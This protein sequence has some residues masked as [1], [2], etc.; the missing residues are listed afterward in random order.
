VPGVPA[1]PTPAKVL[2][3]SLGRP[4]ACDGTYPEAIAAVRARGAVIVASAGNSTGHA[5]NVPANCSGVIGVAAVR[6]IGTKVGFSDVGPELTIAAPGGNCVNI[7]AGQPCLFPIVTTSNSGTTTPGS[8]IYTDSFNISVGT[9]FSAPLVSATVALMVSANS[10]LTPDQVRRLLRSTARSFPGVGAPA[11]DLG[12][13]QTCRPPDG[14]DQLQCYCT[15]LT[16]GAGLLDA[17]AAVQQSTQLVAFIDEGVNSAQAGQTITFTSN[18]T[19]VPAGRTIASYSWT[20]N[21]TVLG[22]G[23]SVAVVP[24]A[25]GVLTVDLTVTDS[26]GATSTTSSTVTVSAAPS[27]GGGGGGGA[28]NPGWLLA[29]C[30]AALALRRAGRVA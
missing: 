13:I 11:D 4:G 12:P 1:N 5:V 25:A 16:C 18:D 27:S 20:Q 17:A 19:V 22:T 15:T 23:S 14:V 3:L 26:S 21:G 28:L 7:A 10:S 9:S 24:T 8:S 2:N 6:H 30:A 29:L